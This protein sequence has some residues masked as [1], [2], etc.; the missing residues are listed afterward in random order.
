MRKV[1]QLWD[2]RMG[3]LIDQFEHHHGPVRG[4]HF[5]RS[6]P[7][8]VSGGDDHKIKV[9]N[10][11][12]RR[13]MFTLVGHFG[14][15]RTVQFHYKYPWIV[16]TSDD[17]SIRIWNWEEESRGCICVLTGHTSSVMSA[18]FHSFM[19]LILSASSDKIIRVWDI[20]V[21]VS[22]TKARTDT[23]LSPTERYY[24][25]SATDASLKFVIRGH[26]RGVNWAAFHS[27]LTKIIVSGA[28]DHHVKI[29]RMN[30]SPFECEYW[31][32]NI[33]SESHYS[34]L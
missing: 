26:R 32:W 13:C 33:E 19:E 2:Y 10:Y 22:K 31:C 28:D 1:I 18:S 9:W 16:S 14:K 25:E 6:Q 23:W 20:R 21:L 7:L 17:H 3:T 27:S 12:L 34:E 11:M 4:V 24:L 5:H 30:D 15:I 8:F 29:W